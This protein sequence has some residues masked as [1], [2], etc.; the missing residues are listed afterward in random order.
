MDR[1]PDA[2]AHQDFA[3]FARWPAQIWDWYQFNHL[4]LIKWS[5]VNFYLSSPISQITIF[6]KG[7]YNLYSICDIQQCVVTWCDLIIFCI[8]FMC[9]LYESLI[10]LILCILCMLSI[11]SQFLSQGGITS[12][13][14]WLGVACSQLS[15]SHQGHTGGRS[16]LKHCPLPFCAHPNQ[17][18]S[19][20]R[21]WRGSPW[22]ARDL[23][24]WFRCLFYF[25]RL[26]PANMARMFFMMWF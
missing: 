21:K 4:S 14:R 7:L 20:D 22:T 13:V 19:S 6:L 3:W 16:A 9:M 18:G 8:V 23:Q 24:R 25:L 15:S 2:A 5:Q 1:P 12:L 10:Y 26:P 17:L 11:E